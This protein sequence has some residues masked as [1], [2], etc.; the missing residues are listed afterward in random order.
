MVNDENF[1]ALLRENDN[2]ANEVSNISE[3]RPL[4][5]ND[6]NH[7]MT[8]VSAVENLAENFKYVTRK[9]TLTLMSNWGQKSLIGLTG[10]QVYCNV[11]TINVHRA[12]AYTAHVA[13]DGPPDPNA[14]L[15][16]RTLLR[17]RNVTTDAGD[18]W[19]TNFVPGAKFCHIVF[20][21]A[22]PTEV[23]D[24]RAISLRVAHAHSRK[25]PAPLKRNRSRHTFS[26]CGRK[27]GDITSS[28]TPHRLST[29][30][31]S[32]EFSNRSCPD[33]SLR[34]WNY[35][36]SM[37]MSYAGAKHVKIFLDDEPLNYRPLLLRRAPGNTYYDYVQELEFSAIDDRHE[38][39]K[40][41]DS[42][43]MDCLIYGTNID[44]G[45]P[46]GFV[47]QITIFSTWGDPYYVGLTG[48]ELY[49]TEGKMIAVNE[50]NVCAHPASVNVLEGA[51]GAGRDAR[52]PDKLIDGVNAAVGDGAHSWL[53]PV[54]PAT[55]NRIYFVFDV[56][57]TIYGMKVWNYGKTPSR[58]VKEFG[59]LMDDLLICNGFLD[60]AKKDE[61]IKAQWICLQNADLDSQSPSTSSVDQR[62]TTSGS[63]GSADQG[64]RPRTGV[65]EPVRRRIKHRHH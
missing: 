20:E 10:L 53:A 24:G 62:S 47:L 41:S 25:R 1:L 39:A 12:Y 36:A 8:V 64:A 40:E 6:S 54:L 18:M 3:M 35:N 44:L 9:L 46:T 57:V 65:L 29:C 7:N 32:Y 51:G 2:S 14:I 28:S 31:P 38:D 42:F 22:E 48:I 43:R 34:V 17:A 4:T 52:T 45:A 5:A 56:P 49:D 30:P 60:C 21:M 13:S 55:L 33:A 16:C 15:D 11:H 26:S 37:E 27:R 58:G 23:T 61:S 19:C 63:R 59:I 50:S